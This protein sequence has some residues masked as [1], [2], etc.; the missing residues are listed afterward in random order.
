MSKV[1][2]LVLGMVAGATMF[3]AI[4][5]ASGNDLRGTLTDSDKAA[6]S[7]VNRTAKGDRASLITTLNEQSQTLSFRVQGLSDTSVLLRM[8]VA[9]VVAPTKNEAVNIRPLPMNAKPQ[10]AAVGCEP[11]V[12]VLSEMAKMLQPGRCVT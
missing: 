1:S 10:R 9:P 8:G 11:P 5:Y 12:S 2:S 7:G 4:Q 6:S 3:G